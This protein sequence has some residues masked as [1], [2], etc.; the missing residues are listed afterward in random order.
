MTE[1][2]TEKYAI[3]SAYKVKTDSDSYTFS[4]DS[5]EAY[6]DY[7]RKILL[8]SAYDMGVSVTGDDE[9]LTLSTCTNTGEEDRFI[10]H[11]KRID[12]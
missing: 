6:A 9:I 11:A 7:V 8:R 10:V 1:N 3:F 4:F 5:D 2:G 12:W